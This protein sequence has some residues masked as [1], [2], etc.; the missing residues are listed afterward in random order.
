MIIV[1]VK[2][3]EAKSGRIWIHIRGIELVYTSIHF[4]YI[5]LRDFSKS[6]TELVIPVNH[7]DQKLLDAMCYF[8]KHI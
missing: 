1:E 3:V 4:Q 2:K 5:L 6:I 7:F 8:F